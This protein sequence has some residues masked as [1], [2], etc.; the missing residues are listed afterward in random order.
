[1]Q[2][3]LV[4]GDPYLRNIVPGSCLNSILSLMF[5]EVHTTALIKHN[6]YFYLFDPHSRNDTKLNVS[7]S[8]TVLLV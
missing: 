7:E 6:R 5:M 4:D 1:M 3:S 8:I 2:T